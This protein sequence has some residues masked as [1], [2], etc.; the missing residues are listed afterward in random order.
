MNHKNT[1]V[2][3]L[4]KK[5]IILA[6]NNVVIVNALIT[7]IPSMSMKKIY[8]IT[9]L[10]LLTAFS[11][12]ATHLMGG[13]IRSSHSGGMTYNISAILYFDSKSQSATNAQ[14]SILVCTG[15]GTTL[16][17]ERSSYTNSQDNP[18][19]RIG[20]YTTTYTYTAQGIYQ[21]S[22]QVDNRSGGIL[23]AANTEQQPLFLWSVVNTAFLNSTPVAP[24]YIVEAGVK[25][26]FILDLNVKDTEA[27]SVSFTLQKL[28]KPSPGTCG[29]RSINNQYLYP[30]EVGAAGTYKIDHLAKKLVWLAPTQVGSYIISYVMYEWRSGVRISENYREVIVN[31]SDRPGE[32]VEIPPYE[33]AETA[34]P[35]TTLPDFD[36]SEF[37][38]AV[39]AYPVP[40][41][42][43]ITVKA[44]SKDVSVLTI[45]I[46]DMHGR[47]KD[48]F[49]T[50][51]AASTTQHQFDLRNYASGIYLVK[52]ANNRKSVSKKIVR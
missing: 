27:D 17:V 3:K 8:L 11:S 50:T 33:N 37:S 51:S 32:T 43:F 44:Y 39:D 9:L 45:Q 21:I 35:I 6:K 13:E 28:S 2:I 36:D 42:D 52:A 16:T 5:D 7:Q 12:F 25:Q 18:G 38:I 22:A 26:P 40:T 30:N 19:I 34:G 41:T 15:D 4:S 49:K 1:F 48:T 46:L 14:N 20:T 24:A 23:N 10:S 31:V 29:V 47:V